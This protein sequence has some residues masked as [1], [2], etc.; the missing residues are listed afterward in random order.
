VKL[1][2]AGQKLVAQARNL[3]LEWERIREDALRDESE[4]RGRYVVGCHVS[5]ALYSLPHFLPELLA[6][7]PFLEVKLI[8]DLSRR[9]TEEV[10]SFRADFGVVVNPWEHPDLVIKPLFRDE[11]SL[12]TAKK[13]S[14]LQD[15]YSGEGVLICDL[16]LIQSQSILKQLAK[17]G[18]KFQRTVTSPSLEVITELVAAEAGIGVLPERVATRIKS[19]GLK[20]V[21]KDSP[22]FQDQIS[23]IYRADAQ[24]S[25]ASRAIAKHIEEHIQLSA[26]S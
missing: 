1:T 5:V 13:P 14:R 23:L 11:V 25:K 17:K 8:H 24:K 9:I 7:H 19:F 22:K 10:I 2:H 21:G 3:L 4:I 26:I 6:A 16:E 15:P 18:M 20:P 12:W